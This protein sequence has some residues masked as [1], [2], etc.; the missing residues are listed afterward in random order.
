MKGDR[1][2]VRDDDEDHMS[3][4]YCCSDLKC[5]S[6]CLPACVYN[7][8]TMAN[9]LAS[10]DIVNS[11]VSPP[12]QCTKT[13]DLL[14]QLFHTLYR[15]SELA[16]MR[17]EEGLMLRGVKGGKKML[18]LDSEIEGIAN[19]NG[20]EGHRGENVGPMATMAFSRAR[21][22]AIFCICMRAIRISLKLKLNTDD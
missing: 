5:S 17:K 8:H 12:P 10:A 1:D 2:Y 6:L 7:V 11:F 3:S 21:K 15:L 16:K 20:S 14:T 22:V 9:P 19:K 4:S 13:V 18:D